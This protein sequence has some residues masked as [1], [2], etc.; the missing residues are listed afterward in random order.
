ME[1]QVFNSN[2]KFHGVASLGFHFACLYFGYV[3]YILGYW[4]H[5]KFRW[6]HGENL[7]FCFLGFL[8][9]SSDEFGVKF[10]T[11]G[12]NEKFLELSPSN[13]STRHAWML[14]LVEFLR[15]SQICML[16]VWSK[17][18]IF[19]GNEDGSNSCFHGFNSRIVCYFWFILAVHIHFYSLVTHFLSFVENDGLVTRWL[20]NCLFLIAYINL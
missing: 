3:V 20:R 2:L 11:F 1:I 16:W 9:V 10:W 12:E 8:V 5:E 6:I 7:K 4:F 13:N 19:D 18:V 15:K 14:V 17:N